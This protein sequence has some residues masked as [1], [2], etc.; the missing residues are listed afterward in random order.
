MNK[1]LVL[2][3]IPLLAAS[4]TVAEPDAQEL[5]NRTIDRLNQSQVLSY[6]FRHQGPGAYALTAGWAKVAMPQDN[7]RGG[8][9][10]ARIEGRTGTG[11]R[12]VAAIDRPD[13]YALDYEQKTLW[14]STP[15]SGGRAL[16]NREHLAPVFLLRALSRAHREK[17]AK[18]VGRQVLGQVPCDVVDYYSERMDLRVWIGQDDALPRRIEA[19]SDVLFGDG[20]LIISLDDWQTH[21]PVYEGDFALDLPEGFKRAEYKGRDPAAWD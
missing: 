21:L 18:W 20:A 13:I 7:R 6:S 9:S 4:A 3:T 14:H 8:F 11:E 10:Q 1:L 16:Y 17:Q 12:V 2:L 5:V 15:R 19:Y